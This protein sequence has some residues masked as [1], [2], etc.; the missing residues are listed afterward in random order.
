PAQSRR[1]STGQGR[2]AASPLTEAFNPP[3]VR[4]QRR[5]YCDNYYQEHLKP[6]KTTS[7]EPNAVLMSP[8]LLAEARLA[9]DEEHRPTDEL[10]SDAVRRYLQQ[11]KQP[12]ADAP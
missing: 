1:T 4:V 6:V 11:R 5:S 3:K 7:H 12:Q 8:E 2:M 9:A 10:V